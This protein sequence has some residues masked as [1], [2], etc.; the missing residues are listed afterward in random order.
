M[1]LSKLLKNPNMSDG[2]LRVFH[3]TSDVFEQDLREK[4]PRVVETPGKVTDFGPGFY[5]TTNRT[6]AE[7]YARKTVRGVG[8]VPL[9]VEVSV[10]VR[11]MLDEACYLVIEK[12]DH[13]WL[14]VIMQGRWGQQALPY[15]WIYGRCGDGTT[16]K[17]QRACDEGASDE[18]RLA[19]LR[20]AETVRFYG[21]DQLWFGRTSNS[22]VRLQPCDYNYMRKLNEKGGSGR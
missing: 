19:L 18:E 10:P 1:R 9:V 5:T 21:Y 4:G 11:A 16:R 22:A 7:R 20:P 6:Q 12:Y 14:E 8:G 15:A 13:K 17:V 3:G 2:T